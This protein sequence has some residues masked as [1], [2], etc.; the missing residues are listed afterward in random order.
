[1]FVVREMTLPEMG[2]IGIGGGFTH[3]GPRSGD[4][5][6]PRLPAYTIAKLTGYWNVTPRLR[7]SLDVDNLFDRTYYISAYNHVWIMPGNPRQ[8][9]A[10][11]QYKF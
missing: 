4:T 5:G 10:G 3:V 2:R 9:T 6:E 1:V 11:L 7:L 8:V